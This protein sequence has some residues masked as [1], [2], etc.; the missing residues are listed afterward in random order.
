MTALWRWFV[1]L[2][3]K[4]SADPV[5]PSQRRAADVIATDAKRTAPGGHGSF[6]ISGP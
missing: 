3:K 2:F 4:S 1:S 5:S 6:P